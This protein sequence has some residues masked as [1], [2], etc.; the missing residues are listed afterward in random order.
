MKYRI[1]LVIASLAAA[2]A[3]AQATEFGQVVSSTPVL[4]Q[5]AVPQQQ[6]QDQPAQ[7][8][9]APSGAGALIG[10]LVGGAVGSNLGSGFGRAASTAVGVV[11][12]SVIGNNVEA[13]NTPPVAT[14]LRSCRSVSSVENRVVGWDVSY[15][16]NGQR[17]TSRLAQPPAGDRIELSVGVAMNSGAAVVT[18]VAALAAPVPATTSVAYAPTPVVEPYPTGGPAVTV[19]PRIVIGGGSWRRGW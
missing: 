6:C 17:Y 5:V 10:A 11:A 1:P 16:Y 18:P 9:Q 4:M 14:T 8:L 15:D 19:V 13:A 3:A 12:G 2:G 7:V